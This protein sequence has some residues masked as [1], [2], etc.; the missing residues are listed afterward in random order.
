MGQACSTHRNLFRAVSV[1]DDSRHGTEGE[2]ER[3]EEERTGM[4]CGVVIRSNFVNRVTE[5]FL[6]GSM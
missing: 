3:T 5:M 2:E 6:I 4:S 1:H